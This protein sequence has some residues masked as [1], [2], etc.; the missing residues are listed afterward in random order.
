MERQARKLKLVEPV[1]ERAAA[2]A[3]EPL[4][5]A[6][7][8]ALDIYWG[9]AVPLLQRC[10]DEAMHGELTVE[11]LYEGIKAGVMYGI[12]FKNDE[13]EL[14]DVA[15]VV[16]LEPALYPRLSAMNVLALGGRDLGEFGE[17]YWKHICSWSYLNGLRHMQASA[18]PGMAR[19]LKRLGFKSVYTTMRMDLTE[20]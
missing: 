3:Y 10:I 20:M 1:A 15:L 6:T 9:Q 2:E 5:L 14:P 16:V 13:G 19:M 18:S 17:K 4:L 8:D 12:V 7:V 11:D